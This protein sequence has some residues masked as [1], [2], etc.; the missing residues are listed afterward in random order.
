MWFGSELLKGAPA[1]S[2]SVTVHR[3]DGSADVHAVFDAKAG[4]NAMRDVSL[5]AASIPGDY[6]VDL[7]LLDRTPST[8]SVGVAATS[9][10]S[11]RSLN[12]DLP[13]VQRPDR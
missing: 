12:N 3:P 4:E 1:P 2:Y 13:V 10:E 7:A 11:G 9:V 8:L 5:S 6:R